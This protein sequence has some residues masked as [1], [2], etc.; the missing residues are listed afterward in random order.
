SQSQATAHYKGGKHAKRLKALEISKAKQAGD[1]ADQAEREPA[2]GVLT[3]V[4]GHV[5]VRLAGTQNVRES[6]DVFTIAVKKA[7]DLNARLPVRGAHS[8]TRALQRGECPSPVTRD[9]KAKAALFCSLCKVALNSQ[10]QMEAHNNGS[11]HK[12]LLEAQS[13]GGSIKAY[14]RPGSRGAGAGTADPSG[15]QNKVFHCELCDVRVN[16]ETQLKQ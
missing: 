3:S 8:R 6:E 9:E 11:M 13:G 15:L 4:W 7:S 2:K 1:T 16:S 5:T 12:T 10:S 14:P